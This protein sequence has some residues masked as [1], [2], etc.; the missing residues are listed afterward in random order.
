MLER[1]L[2]D[3]EPEVRALL[4]AGARQLWML[5][6]ADHAAV[7]ATV[8]AAGK[9]HEARR[10]GGL[11]NAVLRRAAREAE[12]FGRRPLTSVWPDWMAAKLKSALGAER[13]EAMALAAA[14]GAADRSHAAAG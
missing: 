12:A 2:E 11:V 8:E 7:S 14:R 10:G 9:W 3:I 13:A 6:V 4:R 5:G 1:P